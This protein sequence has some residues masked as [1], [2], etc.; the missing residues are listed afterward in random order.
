[1]GKENAN[2]A[3]G[4]PRGVACPE[5]HAKTRRRE[6]EIPILPIL[7]IRVIRGSDNSRGLSA[8]PPR[9]GENRRGHGRWAQRKGA[10]VSDRGGL[11]HC[12]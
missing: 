7:P 1:M 8:R 10:R 3:I 5:S 11:P 9:L 4:V 6:E 12:A 2:Q